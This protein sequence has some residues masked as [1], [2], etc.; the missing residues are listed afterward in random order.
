MFPIASHHPDTGSIKWGLSVVL[1]L[2]FVAFLLAW[3][4]RHDPADH[5]S[6]M[7]VQSGVK[8]MNAKMH[9]QHDATVDKRVQT[10]S[11]Q[12]T[13]LPKKSNIDVELV[14]A[15][16][17]EAAQAAIEAK[18]VNG[19]V[20]RRP[21]FVSEVEWEVLQ[22][23]VS[24]HPEMDKQLTH[25]VNKL[26]F[27]KKREAWLAPAMDPARRRVLAG[28]LLAMIPEQVD[29]KAVDPT[30]ADQLAHDLRNYL[31]NAGRLSCAALKHH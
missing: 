29:E 26:L 12:R 8:S 22:D 1:V 11:V 20:S 10:E 24:R 6:D 3:Q 30:L 31:D 16:Q 7:P 23:V 17:A 2:V 21:A 15:R 14:K 19:F 25:L 28:D 5:L 27:Y 9:D 13:S 4:Y 18:P